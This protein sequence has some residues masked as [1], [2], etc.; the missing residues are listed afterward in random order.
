MTHRLLVLASGLGLLAAVAHPAAAAHPHYERL[1]REGT[2]AL[3][4]G[5]AAEAV[6]DLR[7]ACFGY[8]EEP[9]SLVDCLA[10]LALAQAAV[11]DDSGFRD[12]FGRVVEVDE[13]MGAYPEAEIP[14][15]TRRAFE[16]EVAARIPTAMLAETPA[17]AHLLPPPVPEAEAD[18]EAPAAEEPVAAPSEPVAQT[19]PAAAAALGA[20]EEAQL[21]RARELLALALE[22]GDL[23]EPWRLAREV[24]DANPAVREAQHLAAVIAYRASR[25]DDA[26]RYFRRGGDPDEGAP[27]TL[28]YLAVSLYEAGEREAAAE[29]LQRSLPRIEHTPFV[30]SYREKILGSARPGGG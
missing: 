23:E 18:G 10:R 29:V 4:R 21:D 30:V 3:E 28:F 26:V 9:Q 12:T 1:L 6:A 22:R 2:F 14:P 7:L 20:A 8:L 27:E 24:A 15:E 13:R 19:E 17:F 16:S 5:D 11:G 25:W